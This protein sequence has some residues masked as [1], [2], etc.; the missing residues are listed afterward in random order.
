MTRQRSY[1]IQQSTLC[2]ITTSDYLSEMESLI[3]AGIEAFGGIFLCKFLHLQSSVGGMTQAFCTITKLKWKLVQTI[4]A[5]WVAAWKCVGLSLWVPAS[6]VLLLIFTGR[7]T[8]ILS[9]PSCRTVIKAL[10]N[11][12]QFYWSCPELYL[13]LIALGLSSSLLPQ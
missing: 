11:G 9:L 1:S 3:S 6:P 8:T 12:C 10:C 13:K 7:Y 2:P 4:S 5:D